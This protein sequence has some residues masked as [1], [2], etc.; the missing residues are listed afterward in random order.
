MDKSGV[1]YVVYGANA[2]REAA[3]S[4]ESLLAHNAGADVVTIGDRV[5]GV[6]NIQCPRRDAGG[7]WAKLSLDELS[8]FDLTLYL[9]ADTRV[10][11]NIQNGFGIISDGWDMAL[12]PSSNQGNEVLWHCG[13]ADREATLDALGNPEP[14]QL[15][16]GVMFIRKCAETRRL[17]LQWRTEWRRF[18]NQD[19][20]ALL[21]ALKKC[22]VR[23]WLLSKEWNGGAIIQHYFGRARQ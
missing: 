7:R 4:I 16:A 19:Q 18:E 5:N 2:Q 3:Y 8:P 1:I 14:L 22:Q 9:D 13:A 11:G 21:R 23:L 17:F 20:A 10:F 12:A 6:R 15:Q